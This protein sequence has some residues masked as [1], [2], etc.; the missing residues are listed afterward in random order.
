MERRKEESSAVDVRSLR[1]SLAQ[2]SLTFPAAWRHLRST[3]SPPNPEPALLGRAVPRAAPP[4]ASSFASTNVATHQCSRGSATRTALPPNSTLRIAST[5]HSRPC[6]SSRGR[7]RARG[8]AVVSAAQ[9]GTAVRFCTRISSHGTQLFPRSCS[10]G[11]R[12]TTLCSLDAAEPG[13]QSPSS[14]SWTT[15]A[16]LRSSEDRG[17][18]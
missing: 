14:F 17:M 10:R 11:A 15:G 16:C 12:S 3:R 18:Y 1:C 5:G 4:H 9:E 7:R 2:A 6:E 8:S 13:L